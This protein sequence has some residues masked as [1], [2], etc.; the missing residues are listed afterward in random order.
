MTNSK[1]FW[2]LIIANVQLAP[3]LQILELILP[4][5]VSIQFPYIITAAR[6]AR[7]L[8]CSTEIS[9]KTAAFAP[10]APLQVA[11]PEKLTF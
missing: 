2:F 11:R 7:A 5:A 1:Y 4:S 8:F 9:T 6:T 3:S 10:E